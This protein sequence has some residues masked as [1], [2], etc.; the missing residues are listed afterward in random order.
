MSEPEPRC[1]RA[2]AGAGRLGAWPTAGLATGFAWN[3]SLPVELVG[4][5]VGT[6]ARCRYPYLRDTCHF[7]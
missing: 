4:V 2:G 5:A 6:F 7:Q 1:R 3:G